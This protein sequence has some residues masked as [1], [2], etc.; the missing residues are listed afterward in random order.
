MLVCETISSKSITKNAVKKFPEESPETELQIETSTGCQSIDKTPKRNRK[1]FAAVNLSKKRSVRK[2]SVAYQAK[3][4]KTRTPFTCPGC[5]ERICSSF[6][7]KH[8]MESKRD[9]QCENC[10]LYFK[11]CQSLKE[12]KNGRC[13]EGNQKKFIGQ[14]L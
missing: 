7:L 1:I 14:I 11:S 12:H 13:R 4:Q 10:H 6:L 5:K 9:S 3:H 8:H 2:N